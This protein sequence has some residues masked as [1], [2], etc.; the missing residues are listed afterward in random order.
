MSEWISVEDRMPEPKKPVLVVT[1]E[2][3][4]ELESKVITSVF[5]AFWTPKYFISPQE[6]CDEE[7]IE[8]D[9]IA[10]QLYHPENWFN[11]IIDEEPHWRVIATVTHWMPLPELPKEEKDG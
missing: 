7:D 10:G 8:Y 5:R 1:F 4:L 6:K 3:S 9:P 11:C 2:R